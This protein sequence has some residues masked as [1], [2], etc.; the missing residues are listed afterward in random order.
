[1]LDWLIVGG[2][3]HGTHLSH[4]L[5]NDLGVAREALRV[6][7]P[8]EAPL[9]RWREC[10]RATGMRA[11]RSPYVH[12]IDTHPFSLRQFS[13]TA[14]GR[15]SGTLLGYHRRPELE[16]FDAHCARVISAHGLDDLRVRGAAQGLESCA[17]GY[18]V[19]TEG[20]DLRT[21]RV[22]LAVGVSDQPHWP[23]WA[24]C[25]REQGAPIEH[26]FQP[27]WSRGGAGP[28]EHLVVV[29]GG[30][31]AAQTAMSIAE[32]GAARRVTLLTRHPMRIREFDSAPG[33][34]G[35]RFQ[36]P[37]QRERN[38]DRR[39]EMIVTARNRGS[40]PPEVASRLRLALRGPTL[41]LVQDDVESLSMSGGAMELKLGRGGA[42]LCERVV[43][44]T[45]FEAARPGGDWLERAIRELDLPL[46]RCGYPI[47]G[48]SLEW[49]PGLYVTG[50]L[51]ELEIGPVSRNIVGARLAAERLRRLEPT[52]FVTAPGAAPVPLRAA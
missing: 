34:I 14:E 35:P 13:R 50:P 15:R 42:L 22:L 26:V 10:T 27:G 49:R 8:H 41:E 3:V 48:E 23:L 9:A 52:T 2:G 18:R 33:W 40:L 31:S 43:L 7:D 17:G 11:L 36:V 51:A 46:A 29:G 1:M 12:H 38:R 32:E 5:V 44:A 47:V 37:F 24:A 39:R 45:G 16:L 28:V 19:W 6:L 25:F 4:V 30:I 20:S 21:R